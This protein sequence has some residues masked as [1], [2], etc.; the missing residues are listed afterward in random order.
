MKPTSAHGSEAPAGHRHHDP[1]EMHNLD[2]AYEHGDIDIRA[3]IG[4]ATGLAVVTG[5]VFLL[6]WGLFVG[7]ERYAASNDPQLSPL[8]VQAGQLPPEPRLLTNEPA[9]LRKM[10]EG[11]AKR[12][13]GYGWVDQAG[14]VAHIPIED[15]K[16]KL[17]ERGLPSRP[18]EPV[19][20][21]AGT[22]ASSMG[23][24][25]GGRGLLRF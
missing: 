1:S 21:R 14:G 13:E 20:P 18:G 9:A 16:K 6:M 12:L 5:V 4:S 25:S 15:A 24:S 19:D 8:G 11:D 17:V 2:V 10:R 23:E 7:L 3:V 22:R